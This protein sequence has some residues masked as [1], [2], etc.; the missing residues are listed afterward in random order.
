[1]TSFLQ[2]TYTFN[3]M[4]FETNEALK[5]YQLGLQCDPLTDFQRNI[6]TRRIMEFFFTG[7][8]KVAQCY[9]KVWFKRLTGHRRVLFL[10]H[11]FP[12]Q[13]LALALQHI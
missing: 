11:C 3:E 4:Y 9:N 5:R 12:R 8:S 7:A 1:M 13:L 6:Y 10:C 2:K